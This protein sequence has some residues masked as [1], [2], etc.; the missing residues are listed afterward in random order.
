[1]EMYKTFEMKQTFPDR[2]YNGPNIHSQIDFELPHVKIVKGQDTSRFLGPKI[3]N[4]IPRTMKEASALRI[5][6]NKV[7]N[8]IPEGCPCRLCK[9][10]VQGLGFCRQ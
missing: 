10:Y 4:L 3:W 5:F 1:M 7:T 9:D 8:W 2:N 6:K